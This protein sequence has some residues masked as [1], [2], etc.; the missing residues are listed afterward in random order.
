MRKIKTIIIPIIIFFLIVSWGVI[1][2]NLENTE[3]FDNQEIEKSEN[4]DYE[5]IKEE[6]G[7]DL[8]VFSEDNSPVKIYEN[9]DEFYLVFN[10]HNFN[11]NK[12]IIGNL[13]LGSF[14][15]M[16]LIINNINEFIGNNIIM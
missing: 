2:I 12:G 16:N 11:L 1:S 8:T 3:A 15:L 5:R 14:N 7:M 13:L 10:D 6:T 4:I 9:K